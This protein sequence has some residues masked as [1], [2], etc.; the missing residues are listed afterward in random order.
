MTKL[1]P[2]TLEAISDVIGELHG[3]IAKTISDALL[4][5]AHGAHLRRPEV[6]AARLRLLA[7]RLDG[8]RRHDAVDPQFLQEVA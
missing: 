3:Q 8:T 6:V 1:S 4:P 2:Q 5:I 7:D